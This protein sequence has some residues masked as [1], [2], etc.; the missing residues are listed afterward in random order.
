MPKVPDSIGIKISELGDAGVIK[1]NDVVPINAKTDAGVAFTKATKINDLRQTL[2]FENAF[3]SVDAGLDATISGDVFFVY[4]TAAKLWV[5]QYQNNGGVANPILGYDNNQVRLPTSRQIRAVGELPSTLSLNGDTLIGTKY[6]IPVSDALLP[7]VDTKASLSSLKVSSGYRVRTKGA[8]SSGDGGDAEWVFVP[9]DQSSSVT[10]WP[11]LFVCPSTDLTGASGAWKYVLGAEINVLAFGV[12]IS[13]DPAYNTRVLQQIV[14]YNDYRRTVRLPAMTIYV[15]KLT[16]TKNPNFEGTTGAIMGSGGGRGT[17]FMSRDA[18]SVDDLISV[19][20]T[21]T[22]RIT[23]LKIRGINIASYDYY[24]GTTG[25]FGSRSKRKALSINYCGGN[26][27]L[28]DIFIV[29]F[30]Q[31]LYCNEVWDGV[32]NNVRV[33]YC[34]TDTGQGL[35][36][37]VYFGSAGSDNCNNL[38]ITQLHIEFSPYGL[39]LEFCEHVRFIGLKVECTRPT[40]ATF[41]VVNIGLAATKVVFIGAMFVTSPS[42]MAYYMTDLGRYTQ[43]TDCQFSGG[44]PTTTWP[45]QG[46]RWYNGITTSSLYRRTIDNC[47][48]DFCLASNGANNGDDYPIMLANHTYFNGRCTAAATGTT[49]TGSFTNANSGIMSLGYNC[50]V[51]DLFFNFNKSV[52]KTAGALFYFRGNKNKVSNTSFVEGETQPF[53]LAA[54]SF[55]NVIDPIGTAWVSNST[56]TVNCYGVRNIYLSSAVTITKFYGMVGQEINVIP[57]VAG[58]SITKTDASIITQSG[59]DIAMTQ[60]FAYKFVFLSNGRVSQI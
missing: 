55:D 59:S 18:W 29:G 39:Q 23:G 7:Q 42:T 10:N 53:V 20:G 44:A 19:S 48:F 1:E 51:T 14:D 34:S 24:T 58:C 46:V 35:H 52:A 60:N 17:T 37:G 25:T 9:G 33:M 2:G 38:T 4:E 56:G 36:P 45:Y 57:F 41:D 54:G 43:F 49:S 26:V 32:V 15:N 12:G 47:S 31:G 6:G 30:Q 13:T 8:L 27:I 28:E 21:S 3:L 11:D 16:F 50:K 5:L 22:S 40:D